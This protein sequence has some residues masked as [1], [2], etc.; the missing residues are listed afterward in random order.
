MIGSISDISMQYYNCISDIHKPR[1]LKIGQKLVVV[2]YDHTC[3]IDNAL[4]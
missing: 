1:R 2:I 4:R 3:T